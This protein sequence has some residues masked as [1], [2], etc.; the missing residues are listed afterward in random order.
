M[1]LISAYRDYYDHYA[2]NRAL[3]DQAYVWERKPRGV[4]VQFALPA[5]IE[6]SKWRL[7]NKPVEDEV[8][9]LAFTVWF[10]GVPVPVVKVIRWLSVP[11]M[12]QVPINEY[13]YSIDDVPE[14][15]YGGKPKRKNKFF[16]S[17]HEQ[18][19]MFFGSEPASHFWRQQKDTW[20][21]KTMP[22][23]NV[24]DMHR[25]VGSPVFCHAFAIDEHKDVQM[26]DIGASEYGLPLKH[27]V[28]A[29]P[30]LSAIG[31]QKKY[32]PWT[33]F[34]M[35]ERFVANELAPRDLRMDK[36][37]PDKIKAE[38]HGFDKH[39]FRKDPQGKKGRHAHRK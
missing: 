12:G 10:C 13:A 21:G 29:N 26:K 31:F 19:E 16:P 20:N 9:M 22:K 14:S 33:A 25:A 34:Q 8:T 37:I 35:L 5:M 39:S 36:P 24:L 27:S 15:A 23:I 11:M 17:K 30:R 7:R 32:D 4:E 1:K 3:S 2:R 38:S 18:L 6:S 28:L